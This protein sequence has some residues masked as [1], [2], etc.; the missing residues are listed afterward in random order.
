MTGEIYGKEPESLLSLQRQYQLSKA[1]CIVSVLPFA[2]IEKERCLKILGSIHA[3]LPEDGIFVAF[4][5]SPQM[6]GI[7]YRM[8]RKVK[9]GF[10]PFNLP[11]AFIFICY[12]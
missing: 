2:G 1:D 8:F 11:Q 6:Y 12:K 3:M 9:I 7:F 5:S 4:Q 10:N